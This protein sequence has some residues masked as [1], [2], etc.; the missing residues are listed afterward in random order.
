[1]AISFNDVPSDIKVPG[2]YVEVDNS[3]ATNG[4]ATEA[5]ILM[6][7]GQ[8]LTGGTATVEEIIDVFSPEQASTFFGAGSQLHL[9]VK[10]VFENQNTMRV[11]CIPLAD[12][13]GA[14]QAE[15]TITIT[16]TP[17]E[18]G[19]L[20][21]HIAGEYIPVGVLK[22]DTATTIAD[23]ITAK[24]TEEVDLPVDCANVA[25]VATLTA[26]NGGTVG[27]DIDILINWLGA[28]NNHFTPAGL[29][30]AYYLSRLGHS[31]T[32][33]EALP[34]A[35]GMMRVGIPRYRLPREVL[36]KEI[37]AI[38][39]LGVEIKLNTKVESLEELFQQGYDA[40][41]LAL[42]AHRGT[43][44]GIAGEDLPDVIEAVSFHRDVNLGKEVKLGS[45]V[46][47]IGGG[48]AAID[49]A[50]TA[51]RLGAEKVTVLYRRT[52]N[53]MLASPEEIE[54]AIAEGVTFHFLVAP[55]RISSQ[56]DGLQLQCI[57][58]WLSEIDVS[59]R[60]RPR[61]VEGSEFNMSF[62][63]IIVAGGQSPDVP[64]QFGIAT[65]PGNTMQVNLSTLATD[66][67]GVFAGGD[68]VTGPA[69]VIEAIAAGRRAAASIDRYL[70]GRGIID[71]TLA[72]AEDEILARDEVELIPLKEHEKRRRLPIPCISVAERLGGFAEV[73]LGFSDEQAIEEAKR[74]LRCDLELEELTLE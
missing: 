53:E 44:L 57:R 41:F 47:I 17:T 33:F 51:L 32:V 4:L 73:E 29:T 9:M 18:N 35:G 6:L 50:R 14:A 55:L 23:K 45:K 37:D 16:G 7:I 70:G 34:E 38:K 59:G 31:V 56:N 52:R 71:E 11:Q 5:H 72:P 63:N 62:D 30:V 39:E 42:G 68:L 19:T 43:G 66:K 74:C 26:K 13:V 65:G 36:D 3:N 58:M 54:A 61:P 1:M 67:E 8:K 20:H 40:I 49:S 46:G 12:A 15:D 27:N 69:S 2:S 24:I 60:A 10:S 25:G 64:T 22:T 28:E 48:S 21:F